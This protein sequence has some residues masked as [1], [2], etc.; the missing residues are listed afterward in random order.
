MKKIIVS[1]VLS[2]VL[3]TGCGNMGQN[4]LEKKL[5]GNV[6]QGY[7]ELSSEVIAKLEK[8]GV[9]FYEYDEGIPF[10]MPASYENEY[11]RVTFST[12]E[13]LSTD[14]RI[15][16]QITIESQWD[17]SHHPLV[18]VLAEVMEEET[19]LA[20][21]AKQE[22]QL[23]KTDQQE[24]IQEAFVQ[25]KNYLFYEYF[26]GSEIRT[27]EFVWAPKTY[28]P[29]EFI[30]IADQL[31]EYDLLITG[32]IEGIGGQSLIATNPYYY[33]LEKRRYDRDK[34]LA[35]DMSQAASY[36]IMLDKSGNH[37]V[38][39]YGYM[40]EDLAYKTQV[41]EMPGLGQL[42]K[43]THMGQEDFL[44]I[45]EKINEELAEARKLLNDNLQR[46]Y[47][48]EGDLGEFRYTVMVPEGIGIYNFTVLIENR[49]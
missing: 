23:I 18:E 19:V 44:A 21:L 1:I 3:L 31:K 8:A 5:D 20:W 13:L 22:D 11:G 29:E 38:Q 49:E 24:F 9:D 25:D 10:L 35:S 32:Y 36:K 47:Y 6:E 2:M 40:D 43:L 12:N 27:L 39:L 45:G 48:T 41:E 4:V 17:L 34:K 30:E 26:P 46:E 16:T 14:Q 37:S 28:V 42:V 7:L 15:V 33:F